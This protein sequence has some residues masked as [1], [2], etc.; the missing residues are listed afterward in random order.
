MVTHQ[1]YCSYC[2]CIA[3]VGLHEDVIWEDKNLREKWGFYSEQSSQLSR[4]WC[5]LICPILLRD[6][7]TLSSSKFGTGPHVTVKI[8][9]LSAR[10]LISEKSFEKP[11][12]L[13][14]Q[15][16]R[17]VDGTISFFTHKQRKEFVKTWVQS[18]T[19][20]GH[21]NVINSHV[22]YR[23]SYSIS[24]LF[25]LQVSW[26]WPYESGVQFG[27]NVKSSRSFMHAQ[28]IRNKHRMEKRDEVQ[29]DFFIDTFVYQK[30]FWLPG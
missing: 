18:I 30:F 15:D 27:V 16:E 19:L 28:C 1:F 11:R 24:A 25:Y 10:L 6:K 3:W 9:A 21:W 17:P 4:T 20:W 22:V 5:N 8:P 29:T 13:P 23:S 12:V 2:N 14:A 26:H 7:F